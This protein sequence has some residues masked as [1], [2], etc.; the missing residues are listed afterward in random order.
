MKTFK[1]Q[2][3]L[4]CDKT[5]DSVPYR[6]Y[7]DDELMTERDYI[8]DNTEKYV[9]ENCPIFVERGVHELRIENLKPNDGAFYIN[10][11]TVNDK[12]RT[13]FNGKEF[14]I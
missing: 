3:D 2:F 12:P 4:M 9:R 7:I 11:L 6:V 13:L 5:V 1:V 8:W 10:N 14:K